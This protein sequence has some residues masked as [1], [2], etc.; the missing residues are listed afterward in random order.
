MG[1]SILSFCVGF[2]ILH[3]PM[4]M[5]VAGIGRCK[6]IVNFLYLTAF[7]HEFDF[8]ISVDRFKYILKPCCLGVFGLW[9]LFMVEIFGR[10]LMDLIDCN[11]GMGNGWAKMTCQVG[12]ARYRKTDI[13]ISVVCF[14]GLGS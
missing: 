7:F 10:V 13:G 11:K 4:G 3:K 8:Y 12:M 9:C 6:G 5:L 1:L 14:M 2:S